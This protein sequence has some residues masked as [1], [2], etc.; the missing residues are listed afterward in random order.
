MKYLR[1]FDSVSAMTTAAANAQNSFIG[2]A[3]DNGNPVLLN[4]VHEE[5]DPFNGHD[6][7]D[8]GV[9]YNGNKILFATKNVGANTVTDYGNYY[10]WGETT[11]KSDC[12]WNTYRWGTESELTKYNSTD[13]KVTLDPEDD[14][15]CA[16]MGGQWRSPSDAELTALLNQT[17]N[18]W[19]IDYNGSGINGRVFTG[20]NGNTMF[21]PAAGYRYGTSVYVVGST[22]RWLSSSLYS[23]GSVY[24]RI[25]DFNS[26]N[27]SMA[28]DD[29]CLGFSARGVVAS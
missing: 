9:T 18:A 14:P 21:V 2:L 12:T 15:V 10:A 26:S 5:E 24:G 4:H 27:C 13:Q 23:V 1:E 7:V 16:N 20:T 3:Y 19:V 25:L 17:T 8:L 22:A 29:R 11:T 6:Y 28:Y